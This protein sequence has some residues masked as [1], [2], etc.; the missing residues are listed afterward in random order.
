M[1]KVQNDELYFFSLQTILISKPL[2]LVRSSKRSRLKATQIIHDFKESLTRQ[3]TETLE[4]TVKATVREEIA[5]L[6]RFLQKEVDALLVRVQAVENTINIPVSRVEEM[7]EQVSATSLWQ[8]DDT[9]R[10]TKVTSPV[11]KNRK[12]K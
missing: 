3:I 12:A 6:R 4:I 7:E 1:R 11:S 8:D 5:K 10:I 9:R 2:I